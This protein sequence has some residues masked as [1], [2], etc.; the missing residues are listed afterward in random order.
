MCDPD[1]TSGRL[2]L[3]FPAIDKCFEA[4]SNRE[5]V[6]GTSQTCDLNLRDYFSVEES[7]IISRRHFKISAIADEGYA[8]CDLYS[9]NGTQ[10]NG[11]PLRPGEPWFLRAGDVIVLAGNEQ[12]AIEVSSDPFCDTQVLPQVDQLGS[13][14]HPNPQQSMGLLHLASHGQFVVDGIPLAHAHLTPMEQKLLEYLYER[15]GRVCTY[16]EII[17]GVWGYSKYEKTQNNTVAKLVSNLRR[18]LDQVSMGAGNRHIRTIL[19]RG[20]MCMPA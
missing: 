16:D 17:A 4:E 5:I 2:A 7:K 19:G 13:S 6:A 18:K 20:V 10:V 15:A 11:V 12:L 3:R 8:I 1:R 9:L 14:D